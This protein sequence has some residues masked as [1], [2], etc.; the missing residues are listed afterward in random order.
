MKISREAIVEGLKKIVSPERVV[1][2][3]KVLKE[4][5]H[6]RYRKLESIFGIYTPPLPAAVVKLKSAKEVSEVL[7]FLNQH[8]ITCI[9]RTGS[10]ATEGGLEAVVENSVVL[11]GSE[12]NKIIKIDTCNM[13]V[14]AQ[15]G[16]NLEYLEN[17]LRDNGYTTGHSP[18]SKPLAQ[19]GGLVATRSIGQFSTLYGGIEDMV[20]GLEAVFPNGEITRIKNV[21]R[22]ACGPDIRHVIIGNEGAIC[23]ITEVTVKIFKYQPENNLFYGYALR[24]MK[25]GFELLREVMVSG[26]RPSVARLYDAEDGAQHGFNQF[27]GDDCVLIFVAEGPAG[28]ARATGE[29]IEEIISKHKEVRRLDSKII[30]NWFAHLNW[31]PDKIAAER[32][33]IRKNL[34]MGFTTEVSGNWDIIHDMYVNTIKRIREEF[35]HAD[36]L[37]MLGAHSSHSYQTGTNIYFVYDYNVVNCRI[38]EEIHKYHIPLNALIVE[39][40]LKAGGSMV[41]HHGIGKYR[42]NWTKEEHGSAY[43]ILKGLKEVFDPGNIMNSGTIYPMEK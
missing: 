37:T 33:F 39:E 10:S 8:H 27:A 14:T 34:N 32:E 38:E 9:P 22:R 36:D 2:D 25:L 15:C 26:Y 13:L 21:P 43:Y 19:M 4:N 30:E 3:D 17:Q 28:I 42:T 23:Y 11:D 7:K 6:D 35:P 16:V 20:V 31:G 24:D 12:M 5:S 18:Q 41:H 29:G 40:A 1:T